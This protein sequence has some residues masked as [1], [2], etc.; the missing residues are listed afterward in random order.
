[1]LKGNNNNIEIHDCILI[2]LVARDHFKSSQAGQTE[3]LPG[4]CILL[5]YIVLIPLLIG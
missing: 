2:I 3:K 5:S 4:F 1:M